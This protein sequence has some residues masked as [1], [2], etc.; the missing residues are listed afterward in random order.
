MRDGTAPGK[1]PAKPSVRHPCVS[2]MVPPG[3]QIYSPWLLLNKSQAETALRTNVGK[4]PNEL[5]RAK[6][7][8][9]IILYDRILFYLALLQFAALAPY[10]P[11]VSSKP[12]TQCHVAS[13]CPVILV[14]C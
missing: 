13:T 2:I 11:S 9:E 3:K 1:L 12:S 4:C 5:L 8:D 7:M 6:K 10:G 14:K